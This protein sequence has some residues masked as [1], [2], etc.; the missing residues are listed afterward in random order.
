MA[1]WL[2]L[3]LCEGDRLALAIGCFVSSLSKLQLVGTSSQC[4]SSIE[5]IVCHMMGQLQSIGLSPV[6]QIVDSQS[7]ARLSMHSITFCRCLWESEAKNL[8]LCKQRDPAL[9]LA[10]LTK[11][12]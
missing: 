8:V 4:T 1:M 5:H 10:H 2:N 9:L 6:V 3:H 11:K 12:K 7:A